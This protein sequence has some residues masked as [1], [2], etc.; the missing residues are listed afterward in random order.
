MN[1][2][3]FT[4]I[5]LILVITLLGIIAL[6]AVPTITG[7]I[8]DS[9]EEASKDQKKIIVNAAKTYM[10]NHSTK[11]PTDKCY[12]SLETL[13]SEGILPKDT[14]TDPGNKNNTLSGYVIITF[15]NNKYKY[16]YSSNNN[17]IANCI[18][19]ED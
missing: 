6:I 3:G 4:L 11:L 17:G 8:N 10:V 1:N 15:E 18:V 16:E 7:I 9:K 5:E 12:V 14:I 13:N 19:K 2:K